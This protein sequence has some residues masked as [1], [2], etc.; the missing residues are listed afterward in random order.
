MVFAVAAGLAALAAVASLLRGGRYVHP[1]LDSGRPAPSHTAASHIPHEEH[2][3]PDDN[4]P[5]PPHVR[6]ATPQ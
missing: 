5:G 4:G 6:R 3:G 1:G 2:D